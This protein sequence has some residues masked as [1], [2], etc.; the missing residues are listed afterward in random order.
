M[1]RKGERI[2]VGTMLLAQVRVAVHAIERPLDRQVFYRTRQLKC[3]GP[4][5]RNYREFKKT[6][7]ALGKTPSKAQ[8]SEKFL[9]HLLECDTCLIDLKL[10]WDNSVEEAERML[11]EI[12]KRK[13]FWNRKEEANE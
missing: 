5:A 10:T 4:E 7:Q 2:T 12:M 6:K 1:G 8:P 13:V 3:D 11:K 9:L